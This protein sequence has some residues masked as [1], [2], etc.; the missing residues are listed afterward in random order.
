MRTLHTHKKKK[1][2]HTLNYDSLCIIFNPNV[3]KTREL[4]KKKKLKFDIVKLLQ[5]KQRGLKI[6]TILYQADFFTCASFCARSADLNV[7]R[8]YITKGH[9][10]TCPVSLCASCGM[11]CSVWYVFCRSSQKRRDFSPCCVDFG[12]LYN[13]LLMNIKKRSDTLRKTKQ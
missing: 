11:T 13:V 3:I 5:I 10:W 1:I 6:K 4:K 12:I 9:A 7:L 8:C 2:R